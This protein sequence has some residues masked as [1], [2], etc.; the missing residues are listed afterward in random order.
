MSSR[1]CNRFSVLAALLALF[2][3]PVLAQEA[4]DSLS[5]N[6]VAAY[7]PPYLDGYQSTGFAPVDFDV[8]EGGANERDLGSGWGG[9]EALATL[10]YSHVVPA[11]VGDGPFFS[12]N[13]LEMDGVMELSPIT[14]EAKAA[15]ILTPIAFCKLEAGLSVATGWSIAGLAGLAINPADSTDPIEDTPFGGAVLKGWGAGTFQFDL[16][17]FIPGDWNHVVLQATAKFECRN[18]TAADTGEAWV[19]QAD[20]GMN[21]NGWRYLGT[22]VL[23]YQMPSKV[24]FVGLMLETEEYIG[25]V[26]DYGTMATSWGSNFVTMTIS[27][28][29]NVSFD[30]R[31]SLT[32]IVQIKSTQDWSDSTTQRRSFQ[33]RTYEGRLF[34]LNR[35]AFSY[36]RKLK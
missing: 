34:C 5:L 10:T 4:K 2:A 21:F 36:T 30:E 1:Y 23:G 26:R 6:V 15:F 8:I 35:I 19:W 20:A 29:A 32:F 22:Y 31:N 13:N 11:F 27:P 9:A 18:N 33:Q 12:G 17:A 7:K 25:P 24:N 16:A 14:L 3:S 28:L